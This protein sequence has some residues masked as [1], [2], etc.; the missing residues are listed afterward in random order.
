ME[1]FQIEPYEEQTGKGLL[2]HVMTRV[3]HSTGEIMVCLVVN[4]TKLPHEEALIAA[5][6][7]IPGMASITLNTNTEK[8]NV[9]MGRKQR[10]LWGRPYIE[11]TIGAVRFRISPLSFFQV[12][13]LQTEKL[14]G[15]ALEYAQTFRRMRLC[16]IFTAEL[17]QFLCFLH[18]EAKMVRGVEIIPAAIENARRECAP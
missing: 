15:K 18:R 14:Y 5:L 9:I 17:E 13:P 1:Q 3:G 16:G 4:G 2:R 12:N 11:D 6:T 7:G 8:T 10:L